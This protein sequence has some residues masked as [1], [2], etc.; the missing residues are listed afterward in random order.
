MEVVS[1]KALLLMLGVV[2]LI[3]QFVYHIISRSTTKSIMDGIKGAVKAFGPHLDESS[4][5]HSLVK[6]L[7]SAH[8][9]KNADG[10]PIWYM[11]PSM[12]A[13]QDEMAKIVHTMAQTQEILANSL[14]RVE[15][16]LDTH[17]DE[18]RTRSTNGMK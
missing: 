8:D 11:P 18:C 3:L 9:V 13:I 5:I 10:V 4:E 15:D 14:N 6:S 12:V 7:A 1:D 2:L 16:K 17:R